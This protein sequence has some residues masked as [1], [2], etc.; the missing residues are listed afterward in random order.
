M[1]NPTQPPSPTHA[2]GSEGEEED[3]EDEEGGPRQEAPAP[4]PENTG[5]DDSAAA[6]VGLRG[7]FV[8]LAGLGGS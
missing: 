2:Q 5:Y 1:F 4:E 3:E 6:L 7:G 8:C